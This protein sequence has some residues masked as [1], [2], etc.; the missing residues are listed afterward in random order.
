MRYRQIGRK[1]KRGDTG[2]W[3]VDCIVMEWTTD[4]HYQ[5]VFAVLSLPPVDHGMHV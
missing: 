1:R 3:N 5:F 4:D 2:P